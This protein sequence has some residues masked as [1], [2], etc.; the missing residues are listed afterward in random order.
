VW[1]QIFSHSSDA[2]SFGVEIQAGQLFFLQYQSD[3]RDK[4]RF[5]GNDFL[6]CI[7][8]SAF[9]GRLSEWRKGS[10]CAALEL[11][12]HLFLSPGIDFGLYVV[13]VPLSD[14]TTHSFAPRQQKN[15]H[16]FVDSHIILVSVR[17]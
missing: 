1:S 14:C 9:I 10:D 4:K 2:A 13:C 3:L 6:E 7:Y 11:Q 16:A 17:V 5:V 8:S 12:R 15:T